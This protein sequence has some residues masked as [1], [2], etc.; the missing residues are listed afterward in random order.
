[1]AMRRQPQLDHK[2]VGNDLLV[3]PVIEGAPLIRVL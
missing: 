1:M 3:E 2:N